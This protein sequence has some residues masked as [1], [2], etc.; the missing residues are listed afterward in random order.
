MGKRSPASAAKFRAGEHTRRAKAAVA[1]F[2]R[3]ARTA[4]PGSKLR[5][6]GLAM[7]RFGDQLARDV[8]EIERLLAQVRSE[9]G[10]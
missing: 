5:E 3:I 8:R 9:A 1:E 4:P 10:Q 2:R 6:F 7:A